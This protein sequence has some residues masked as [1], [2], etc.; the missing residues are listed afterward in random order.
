MNSLKVVPL[1]IV[2]AIGGVAGQNAVRPGAAG[3]ERVRF[4]RDVR[5]I[6]STCF[7]CHGPDESSRR[8][9]LRLDL[10][11]EAFKPRR[12]GTPIVPGKPGESLIISR[13]FETN[14]ARVMP[15]ASLHKDLTDAQ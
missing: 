9:D 4:N 6:L 8:A 11:D 5:P 14:P 12:N 3:S 10:R 13:I 15:P 1:A 2:L 7:R